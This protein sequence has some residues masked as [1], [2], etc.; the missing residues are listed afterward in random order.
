MEPQVSPKT[1]SFQPVGVIGG[2]QLAQMLALAAR[3]LGIPLIVQAAA[4]TDPAVAVADGVVWGAVTDTQATAQ[5]LQRCPVVTFENEFIPLPELRKLDPQGSRFRPRLSTLEPLLDKLH[6]RQFL[7]ELGV[8]VPAF[9]PAETADLSGLGFPVVLKQRRQGYDGQGTRILPDQAT[10]QQA[11]AE[12]AG[13]P[14]LLEEWIPFERE[15][16]VIVA[17]GLAGEIQL[18]PVVETVQ[19]EQVCRYVLAPARIPPT[20][21]AEIRDLAVKVMD[22]LDAVGVFAIELFWVPPPHPKAG[23]WINEISP[24]V[25]NSGH[26]TLEACHTSQFEQHLRAILGLPLGDPSLKCGGAV[27]VNLLGYEHSSS[28]YAQKRQRLAGIPNATLHWYHKTPARPGRK[29]GHVT[30]C[31]PHPPSP[32]E[33]ADLVRTL[34]ALWY[35][36][37]WIPPFLQ[38]SKP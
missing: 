28:D 34:E 23:I 7:A 18:Y 3:P 17:R 36:Q 15:L 9:C 25:H 11:L 26:Y 19:I 16:A 21:E 10:L 12:Y 2:G 5:L 29:L 14:L 22:K 8:P 13:I 38:P 4:P 27:M 1:Q 24:R 20:V 33:A 32:A 6:Q 31:L 37:P 30:V 35:P